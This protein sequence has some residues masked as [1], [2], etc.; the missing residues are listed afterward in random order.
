MKLKQQL[1]SIENDPMLDNIEKARR[2]EAL[3]LQH[4]MS[5]GGLIGVGSRPLYSP[6]G[7]PATQGV[8]LGLST[9]SP[10]APAFYPPGDTVESVVGEKISHSHSLTC[11]RAIFAVE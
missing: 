4:S 9:M 5:A 8:G 11:V 2:K 10:H 1:Q 7:Q 3:I 6:I